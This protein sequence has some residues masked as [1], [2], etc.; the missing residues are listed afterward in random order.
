MCCIPWKGLWVCLCHKRGTDGGFKFGKNEKLETN[1]EVRIASG[2]DASLTAL[3]VAENQEDRASLTASNGVSTNGAGATKR[4]SSSTTEKRHRKYRRDSGSRHRSSKTSDSYDLD[5]EERRRKRRSGS[6]SYKSDG[7]IEAERIL[8]G[9]ATAGYAGMNVAKVDTS[10]ATGTGNFSTG[11]IA[12]GNYVVRVDVAIALNNQG[13]D[14]REGATQTQY[15]TYQLQDANISAVTEAREAKYQRQQATTSGGFDAYKESYRERNRRR[16]S[17]EK[18][19]G[20]H[21]DS[22]YKTEERRRNV[23]RN[24][25]AEVLE[26]TDFDYSPK[27]MNG[28][29]LPKPERRVS[30][31][32]YN[33]K[34]MDGR[35]LK[36]E[37]NNNGL[38]YNSNQ[39]N[40]SSQKSNMKHDD[41]GLQHEEYSYKQQRN[42]QGH[43]DQHHQRQKRYEEKHQQQQQEQYHE[44]YHEEYQEQRQQEKLQKQQ[45]TDVQYGAA[46]KLNRHTSQAGGATAGLVVNML[47]RNDEAEHRYGEK[48]RYDEKQRYEEK[49]RYDEKQRYEEKPSTTRKSGRQAALVAGATSGMTV[50]MEKHDAEAGQWTEEKQQRTTGRKSGRQTNQTEATNGI[51]VNILHRDEETGY[52]QGYEEKQQTTRKSG[53]QTKAEA[54]AGFTVNMSKHDAEEEEW[55]EEKRRAVRKTGRQTKKVES[56]DEYIDDSSEEQYQNTRKSARTKSSQQQAKAE[57]STRAKAEAR[58]TVTRTNSKSR[59]A[60]IAAEATKTSASKT[61]KATKTTAE[62][63]DNQILRRR[64]T[65]KKPM[66]MTDVDPNYHNPSDSDSYVASEDTYVSPPLRR[67]KSTKERRST[68]TA[69]AATTTGVK[70]S[71]SAKESR[72]T[73]RKK[74]SSGAVTEAV[75]EFKKS[76]RKSAATVTKEVAQRVDARSGR[77]EFALHNLEQLATESLARRPQLHRSSAFEKLPAVI[78]K[79]AFR[80]AEAQSTFARTEQEMYAFLSS[81]ISAKSLS[82][83]MTMNSAHIKRIAS[84]AASKSYKIAQSLFLPNS[85]TQD[86]MKIGLY[87]VIVFGDDSTSMYKEE[88]WATLKTTVK[89]IARI[90]GA[91]NEAGIRLRFINAKNDSGFNGVRTEEQ[92]ET[93][94]SEVHLGRGTALGTACFEKVVRK[95]IVDKAKQGKLLRPVIVSVV[96]DGEVCFPLPEVLEPLLTKHLADRRTPRHSQAHNPSSQK[97]T[98]KN[99]YPIRR[100]LRP[101][102]CRLPGC[103]SRHQ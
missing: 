71:Q 35:M 47:H 99:P 9:R 78:S 96:T 39:H 45:K 100:H 25:A 23:R 79:P 103:T 97:R 68:K 95:E 52:A 81:H 88:R 75:G 51:I 37:S 31:F 36:K 19:G 30:D 49:Q 77:L 62:D 3:R 83:I 87:D 2:G 14:T 72:T 70:R 15:A 24:T 67:S 86:L 8:T 90:A 40:G 5:R 50:N 27:S 11:N 32:D 18:T 60:T 61:T 85:A 21:D 74:K 76:A 65:R 12:A 101:R 29:P 102:Q 63:D 64:S 13:R 33:A 98:R 53:R 58:E 82:S 94:L 20:V 38:L 57:A 41:A 80:Y 7:R 55:Q 16:N 28:Q 73:T 1:N 46:R 93:C 66:R 4:R 22:G 10:T 43:H 44:E 48:Q 92:V 6:A 59:A 56:D 54:T 17:I 42:Q 89:R 69:A 34:T 84:S 91:Y 26:S